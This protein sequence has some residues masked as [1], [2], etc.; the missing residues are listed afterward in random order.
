[1]TIQEA[2]KIIESYSAL[3]EPTDDER[4]DYAEAM[5]YLY[6]I[7]G[8]S[9]FLVALGAEYYKRRMFDFA[10]RYYELAAEKG[11]LS[12]V[13]N[14]GYIY[15]Y[16]RTGEKDYEKAYHYFDKAWEMG[17]L[18]AAYKVADMYQN[19][20][21]VAKSEKKYRQIIEELYPLVRDTLD[22]SAPLPEIYTRLARIRAERGYTKEALSLFDDARAF[23]EKRIAAEPFFGDL[24]IM[25][26]MI[27]DI[28][29]LRQFNAADMSLYDLYHV[30]RLPCRVTFACHGAKHEVESV[31]SGAGMTIRYEGEVFAS[32]DD[33]FELACADGQLL[34]S[35]YNEL[36][37][38]TMRAA[39]PGS[40]HS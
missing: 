7:T 16:G 11:N 17:D 1:M 23:L 21:Y 5:N 3:T 35:I 10:L 40:F 13:S 9:D 34:T 24:S 33:F 39:L 6:D 8:E 37:D 30:L 32:V 4:A 20:Y 12:A 19:G 31:L 14:L 29:K 38:F 18:T 15:Y 28:Y 25:K 27:W 22:L 26:Y 2:Q 36:S